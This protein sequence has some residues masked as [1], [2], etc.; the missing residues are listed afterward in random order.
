VS[1]GAIETLVSENL[2]YLPEVAALHTISQFD[3]ALSIACS[4]RETNP[5]ND[6]I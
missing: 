6:P 4:A 2:D 5:P 3:F 1:G